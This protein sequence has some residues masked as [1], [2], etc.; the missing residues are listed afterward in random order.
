MINRNEAATTRLARLLSIVPWLVNRQGIDIA[1][2]A[3]ELGVDEGQLRDDLELLFMCGYG[4]MT[5]ELIDVSTEGGRIVIS[6]ADTIAEPLRLNRAEALTL[7]VALRALRSAEGVTDSTVIERTLAK[8][9]EAVSASP[10]GGAS[11]SAGRIEATLDDDSAEPVRE[12]VRAA[13]RDRRR[14]HLRYLVPARDESTQRDVDP[15]R[16]VSLDGRWY[17]EGWCHRAE[18]TRL[19]RLDR[20]EQIDILPLDGTPPPE[21]V[22]RDLSAGTFVPSTSAPVILLALS[23]GWEWVGEYYSVDA[24]E[25]DGQQTRITLR[26]G[27]PDWVRRLALRS[28][29]GVVV[30]QPA[31]LAAQVAA[32]AAA[33]LTAY[34]SD[35]VSESGTGS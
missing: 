25:I 4:P 6:N 11:G 9:D 10:D 34:D 22:A 19:F 16:L 15:M 29:G 2:A 32:D 13:L 12:R 26:A 35:S 7:T 20:I 14:L 18:D 31:D 17:L 24:S 23:R 28:G 5:D 30:L 1:Q 8:L 27:D 3:T 33:A 21:A